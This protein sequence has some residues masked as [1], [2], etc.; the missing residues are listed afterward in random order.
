MTD[1]KELRDQINKLGTDMKGLIEKAKGESRDLTA[2]EERSFDAMDSDREKL[3]GQE[4]R[5]L[6]LAE[7]DGSQ[8]RRAEPNPLEQRQSGRQGEPKTVSVMDALRAGILSR[9][10]Q[11]I[12]DT[13]RTAAKA[14]GIPLGA[15]EFTLRGFGEESMPARRG[16]ARTEWE[17]RALSTLNAGSPVDGYYTIQ[18]ELMRPL[19]ESLL[20]FGA[21]R[22]AATVIRTETG[23]ALQIPTDNDTSNKGEIIDENTVINEKDVTFG[24]ITMGSFLYSSKMVRVSLQLLQDSSFPLGPFLGRKL[25]MRI[26][27]IHADHFT[28]GNGTTQPQGIVTAAG[29][30]SVQLAA[31][32]PTYAEMVSI[33]HSI[34]PAYRSSPG[35]GWMFHDSLLAEVKKITDASTG[36]PIWMPNMVGGEPDTILGDPY[37]INQSM[38]VAAGSGAGKSILY[39]DLSKYLIRDVRDVTIQVVDQLYAAYHQVAFFAFARTDA[40]LLD[41][42]T[43]PVKYALNKA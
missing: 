23:A 32:T 29:N 5:A 20:A 13:Q 6:R 10:G 41:A 28:T 30:S 36:R 9:A 26:G 17:A 11:P 16:P 40:K 39:G 21:V 22:P 33:Q 31:Q 24:Q 18:N 14:L 8:G 19:E 4:R 43:D 37:F 38:A 25:G 3:L 1:P 15:K 27:R 12:T 34:D 7:L 2:D 35:V 42:G